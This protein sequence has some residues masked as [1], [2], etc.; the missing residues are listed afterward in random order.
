MKG[1]TGIKEQNK[2]EPQ[3]IHRN[4]RENETAC[5]YYLI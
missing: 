2:K 4:W 1:K 5:N 3:K